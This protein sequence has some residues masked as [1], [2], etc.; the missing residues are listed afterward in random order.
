MLISILKARNSLIIP[1]FLLSAKLNTYESRGCWLQLNH[2]MAPAKD[3]TLPQAKPRSHR[4]SAVQTRW[5]QFFYL[6]LMTLVAIATIVNLTSRGKVR[7]DAIDFGRRFNQ[8]T[9]RLAGGSVSDDVDTVAG[10]GVIITQRHEAQSLV[11]GGG[12]SRAG[13]DSLQ[14]AAAAVADKPLLV[15]Y[16]DQ[17]GWAQYVSAQ[18][19]HLFSLLKYAYGWETVDVA[20][21]DASEGWDRFGRAVVRGLSGRRPDV[22]LFVEAFGELANLQGSRDDSPLGGCE[23]W[24]FINDLHHDK[25][26]AFG[27]E[28][29][30]RAVRAAD[31]ILGPYMYM[32]DSF[33]PAEA[34]GKK[35]EWIPHA[36]TPLF[37]LP[38]VP[39][40]DPGLQRKVL[41]T[42][43]TY[44]EWYP[45]RALVESKIR[46]GDDRFVQQDHPGYG[47][48]YDPRTVGRGFGAIL[49][50]HLACV[51]DGLTLNYTVAKMFELPAAGCLLLVNSEVSPVLS[52]LGFQPNV[53]YIP[54]D[55]QSL[56]SIV[57][58]V[59]DP[60]NA[61]AVDAIRAQGQALVWA[62]HTVQERAAVMH[63]RALEGRAGGAYL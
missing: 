52:V 3:M 23:V 24:L 7:L 62:R 45:Y 25:N 6:S 9:R 38:L 54:Y 12:A 51:T 18:D 41:L 28:V 59:L 15:L 63:R 20:P 48:K 32:L 37:Q 1:P 50:A 8:R 30:A 55:R 34:A 60:A 26:H 29:K 40:S 43:Q 14:T 19:F 21:E 33:F 16:G 11:M 17:T 44:A 5:K 58:A 36:A 39:S 27:H 49:N 42:G 57:D 47:G 31:V 4:R 22:L 13:R 61:G 53:H 10:S 46:S 2:R 56:D 35:R